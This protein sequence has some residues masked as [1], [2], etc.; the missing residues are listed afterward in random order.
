MTVYLRV[1]R[2]G[3][4]FTDIF[5][6]SLTID[7]VEKIN[8]ARTYVG[9]TGPRMSLSALSGSS[10]RT[11]VEL[12]RVGERRNLTDAQDGAKWVVTLRD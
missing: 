7:V 5:I 4:R 11:L 9:G 8:S 10:L 12:G 3:E 2:N 6:D 1:E